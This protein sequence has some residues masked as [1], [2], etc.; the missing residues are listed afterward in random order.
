MNSQKQ[1]DLIT[2]LEA[3]EIKKE[4]VLEQLNKFWLTHIIQITKTGLESTKHGVFNIVYAVIDKEWNK[5][6]KRYMS[7]YNK[8]DCFISPNEE[9]FMVAETPKQLPNGKFLLTLRTENDIK[10][11]YI[12]ITY[13]GNP[14]WNLDRYEKWKKLGQIL[15]KELNETNNC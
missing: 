1:T 6:M 10:E 8:M 5:T 9:F 14:A 12:P 15:Y 7:H 13:A 2:D 4:K 3:L 11:E